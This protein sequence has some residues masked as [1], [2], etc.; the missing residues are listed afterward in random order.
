MDKVKKRA[1]IDRG[2]PPPALQ[3]WLEGEMEVR[4]AGLSSSR[5]MI[6]IRY[7][8]GELRIIKDLLTLWEE[9]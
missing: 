9:E 2:L 8:Q 1:I 4:I 6:D 5:D 3:E 7:Y